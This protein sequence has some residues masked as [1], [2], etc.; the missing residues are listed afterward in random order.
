[1]FRNTVVIRRGGGG[2]SVVGGR[3]NAVCEVV[4]G[5]SLGNP[6]EPRYFSMHSIVTMHRFKNYSRLRTRCS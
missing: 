5:P 2:G 1:M 4:T 6:E 3:A